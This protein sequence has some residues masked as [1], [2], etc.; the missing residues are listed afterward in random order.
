MR[1]ILIAMAGSFFGVVLFAVQA[2]SQ[3][4]QAM[5]VVCGEYK[6]LVEGLTKIGEA[7]VGRAT[8]DMGVIEL[9]LNQKDKSGTIVLRV[10]MERACLILAVED[11]KQVTPGKDT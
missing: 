1:R 9:W 5:P 6:S 7:V 3:T 11:F 8:N 2:Y 10:G 4:Q